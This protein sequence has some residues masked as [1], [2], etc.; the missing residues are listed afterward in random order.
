[1]DGVNI[2]WLYGLFYGYDRYARFGGSRHDES[3]AT[4]HLKRWRGE[5]RWI[6]KPDCI[7]VVYITNTVHTNTKPTHE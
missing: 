3:R 1:M 6:L 7:F 4:R 2:V 5:S